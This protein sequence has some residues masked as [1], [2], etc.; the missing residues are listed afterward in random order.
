LY[1]QK[2]KVIN[3]SAI[4]FT[5]PGIKTKNGARVKNACSVLFFSSSSIYGRKQ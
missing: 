5:N 4:R 1:L 2:K 3:S